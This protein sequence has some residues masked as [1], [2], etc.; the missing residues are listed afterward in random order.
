LS[1]GEEKEDEERGRMSQAQCAVEEVVEVAES[2]ES[3]RDMAT[4][5]GAKVEE[6]MF[7]VGEEKKCML[8][9]VVCCV[10]GGVSVL[11]L[12]AGPA[13]AG[14]VSRCGVVDVDWVGRCQRHEMFAIRCGW[15][16][17]SGM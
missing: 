13:S 7:E 3:E 10:V 12:F 9:N 15:R 14:Y 4:E 11:M 6:R 1:W 5:A 2:R 16:R 17:D 8:V